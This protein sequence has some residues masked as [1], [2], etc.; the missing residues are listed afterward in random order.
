MDVS[1]ICLIAYR[2][3]RLET[4][5]RERR[6]PQ[7][8]KPVSARPLLFRRLFPAAAASE[9]DRTKP[10]IRPALTII[11]VNSNS[12]SLS[13]CRSRVAPLRAIPLNLS[14]PRKGKAM[15]LKPLLFGAALVLACGEAQSADLS[16]APAP[17]DY[18][19]VCDAFGSGFFFIPGTD[20]CLR[21]RGRLRTEVRY[22]NQAEGQPIG[23]QARGGVRGAS[24]FFARARGYWG[25]DHRTSTDIGLVR[26]FFRGFLT[27]NS[28]NGTATALHLDYAFIQLG[29][30]GTWTL[31]FADM[32]VEPV[33][34]S[35]VLDHSFN[36]VGY[37]E[38]TVIAQ[39]VYS[40]G[41]GFSVGAL[42][43]DPTTG[44]F[45]TSTRTTG[46]V[47]AGVP[48][49]APAYGGLRLP[50][51]GAAATYDGEIG[52]LRLAG[53]IQ[54]IRPANPTTA[55]AAGRR[56]S[57]DHALGWA[58]G[59]SGLANLPFGT[60]SKIGF[61]AQYTQGILQFLH[62][63]ATFLPV[64]DFT[65]NLAG[66]STKLSKGWSAS[67]GFSTEIID[68]TTFN[69]NA[70]YTDIRQNF[71]VIDVRWYDIA[72]N[73]QH[74]LTDNLVLTAEAHYREVFASG[75]RDS[76]AYSTIL[77]AQLDF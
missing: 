39:Y 27:K 22:R 41:N 16:P 75:M 12:F 33:F 35:Y 71:G 31:G 56:G 7:N 59:V 77:R 37:D 30:V 8:G 26:A 65:A 17:V 9:I 66:T 76:D 23:L 32:I 19:R 13:G 44:A 2:S 53:L 49:T 50:S 34:Q 40:F 1:P 67:A 68:R 55:A 72:A 64:G 24:P 58:I 5:R 4:Q 51:L 61:N 10:L 47:F 45:G 63:D 69:L 74:R 70:G 73:L 20:S 54:D 52:A 29:Q 43:L 36:T 11:G 28:G 60:N 18:V 46:T 48:F 14:L 42:I 15:T 25:W 3:G 6:N 57:N 62:E 38:E 21:L